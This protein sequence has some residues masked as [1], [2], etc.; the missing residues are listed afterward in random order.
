MA[1]QATTPAEVEKVRNFETE[2][3]ALRAKLAESKDEKLTRDLN[4]QIRQSEADEENSKKTGLGTRTMVGQTRGKNPLVIAWPAFD[5]SKPETLPV[6]IAQFVQITGVTNEYEK[7]KICLVSL[8]IAGYND[9]MYTNASD[10]LAEFVEPTWPE[11][12]QAQFRLVTRNYSRGAMV[13]LEEAVA[14]VK[15]G[16]VKQFGPKG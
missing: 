4:Q 10:P 2:R 7:D 8:L 3:A 15:P 16:F 9:A 11:E 1:T 14:L 13:P 6:S 5:D 12:A